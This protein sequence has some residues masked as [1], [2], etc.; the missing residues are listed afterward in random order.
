MKPL[1]LLWL[2]TFVSR[3]FTIL[4]M[5]TC[6]LLSTLL[7][8]APLAAQD[9][10]TLAI[11]LHP[12]ITVTGEVG[13]TYVIESK[14]GVDD[15]I[16]LTR[17]VVELTS[18]QATWSDSV[19]ADGPKRIYRAVKQTK[20]EGVQPIENMVWIPAGTFT[21]GSPRSERG[22]RESEG[23]QTRVTLT[24]SFWMGKY[25]LTQRAYV[26][27]M[28][29]NPSFNQHD[30]LPNHLDFPVEFVSWSSAAT[31]CQKLTRQ[32]QEAGRVP[33]GWEYRLPTEAEWEYACRAGTT[34]R[35]SFGDALEC[36]DFGLPCGLLDH[37]VWWFP[38]GG[39]GWGVNLGGQK[40]PN[41]WGLHDMHGNCAEW[42]LDWYG[43]D[44]PG[45][46]VVDPSGPESGESRVTRS[47]VS[48]GYAVT[49][50]SAIR[51]GTQ[52]NFPWIYTG[53]RP[54]L[55]PVQPNVTELSRAVHAVKKIK[56]FLK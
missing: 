36:N 31:Y 23:P 8:T 38:N 12:A 39:D 19:P 43:G 52:P 17:G 54:V 11:Q 35:F 46:V 27:L 7:L 41:P 2:A 51:E 40:P 48:P 15:D 13:S 50:R 22:G 56:D 1:P 14:N 24:Q 42:C 30:W 34:A 26:E 47:F 37:Y 49:L 44:H 6:L 32:E 25:E 3:N 29:D 21:M 28:E 9:D 4:A 16:W 20:P 53:F 45:G 5:K 10:P 55:A 33:L 18:T